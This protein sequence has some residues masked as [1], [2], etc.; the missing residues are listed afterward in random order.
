MNVVGPLYFKLGDLRGVSFVDL[1]PED[2]EAQ[3]K[4]IQQKDSQKGEEDFF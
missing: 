1:E 4:N 3:P 2:M